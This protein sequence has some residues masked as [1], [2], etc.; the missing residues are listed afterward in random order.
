M[1]KGANMR[2]CERCLAYLMSREGRLP[3]V[4]VYVDEDE[5][6]ESTCEWCE[7]SGFDTLYELL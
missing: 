4:A 1:G 7:E 2:V 3:N 6:D 5:E